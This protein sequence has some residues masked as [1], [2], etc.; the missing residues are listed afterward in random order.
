MC[1]VYYS[2]IF[3]YDEHNF[4]EDGEVYVWGGGSE[5]QLGLG[6]EM[7]CPQP[8]LLDIEGKVTCLSCGYYHTALVTGKCFV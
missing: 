3:V 4:S 7:E 6:D 1:I 2:V 5:G 8:Q